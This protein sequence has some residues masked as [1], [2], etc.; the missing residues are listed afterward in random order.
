MILLLI[1]PVMRMMLLYLVLLLVF[2]PSSHIS[3]AVR[4]A[5]FSAAASTVPV[6][7]LVPAQRM[8]TAAMTHAPAWTG[9]MLMVFRPGT[10]T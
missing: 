9:L 3:S 1:I 10:G 5:L 4:I 7:R 2:S 8:V 6:L